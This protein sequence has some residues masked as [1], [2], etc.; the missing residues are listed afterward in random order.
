[1]NPVCQAHKKT[2]SFPVVAL[3]CCS[4]ESILKKRQLQWAG[5]IVR[6]DDE[7]L[8][9]ILLYG[10]VQQETEWWEDREKA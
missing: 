1:M 2:R 9:K 5:H 3:K 6:M 8:P 10:Q 4:I 7:R